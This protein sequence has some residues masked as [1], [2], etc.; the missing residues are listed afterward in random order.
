MTG[1]QAY[2]L[3]YLSHYWGDKGNAGKSYKRKYNKTQKAKKGG[4]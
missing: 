3:V 4:E 2:E 1:K